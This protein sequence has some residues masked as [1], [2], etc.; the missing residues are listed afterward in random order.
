[1]PAET[2]RGEL[3]AQLKPLAIKNY[4]E[5]SGW[6]PV[7][8]VRGRLWVYRHPEQT[9][10]QVQIPMDPEDAG[11]TE[12]MLVAVERLAELT[13]RP[14]NEVL[15]DLQHPDADL[16]RFRLSS[17][18]TR[19]GDVSIG[20]DVALREGARRALLA[21]A[22]SAVNP[23]KHHARMTRAQVETF[24]G[25]CRSGQSE[26]GSY[27]VKV[28]CPLH[29]VDDL[30]LLRGQAPFTRSV[31]AL[32]MR[33]VG[34]LVAAIEDNRVDETL[35][36]DAAK[37]TISSNL[38]D[39]LVRMRPGRDGGL[40]DLR[41]SWAADPA[42]PP[43]T[44]IAPRVVIRAEYF[45]IIER[46]YHLLRPTDDAAAAETFVGTVET[47]DGDV[48]SEGR[49]SG[50]VILALLDA[51]GELFRARVTLD[52]D[53]YEL[54]RVA[55]GSAEGFIRV[56]G[57]LARGIRT[58]RLDDVSLFVTVNDPLPAAF[59]RGTAS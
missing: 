58:S 57:R 14:A 18:D 55:H 2:I 37:P 41:V 50:D 51:D 49:R 54:A 38:C 59:E 30:P 44:D 16:L 39:A 32:L 12:A 48:G 33:A 25:A 34:K 4:L 46:V 22:S 26:I 11:F 10:R 19:A 23:V 21:A 52:A 27:I 13:D 56:R 9:L 53:R 45:P 36:A 15:I 7:T 6:Q 40:L 3:A 35:A 5:M 29:A 1:M 42:V 8:G 47:L 28:I 43:P 31:T 20:D 17:P 24:I